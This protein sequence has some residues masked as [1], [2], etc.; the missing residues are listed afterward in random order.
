MTTKRCQSNRDI[1]IRFRAGKRKS[2]DFS[3]KREEF[4]AKKLDGSKFDQKFLVTR[5]HL[6]LSETVPL[7]LILQFLLDA[8]HRTKWDK[9]IDE[10]E[11]IES[12]AH[13][14]LFFIRLKLLFYSAEFMEKHFVVSHNGKVYIIIYSV[15]EVFEL[16]DQKSVKAKNIMSVI[17]VSEKDKITQI[18]VINQTDPN[19]KLGFLAGTIGITRQKVWIHNLKCSLL[20]NIEA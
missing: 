3:N 7:K 5:L 14:Y 10:M 2:L 6:N 12:E 20:E 9:L 19:T 18:L 15:D 4:T 13:S 1:K 17:K 16:K 8:K 11:V